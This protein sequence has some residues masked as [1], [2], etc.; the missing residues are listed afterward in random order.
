M[1]RNSL[2]LSFK[3]TPCTNFEGFPYH[4]EKRP[5]RLR[6]NRDGQSEAI[7][8]GIIKAIEFSKTLL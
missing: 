4:I 2:L 1:M 6:V 7:G 3:C 8:D 5:I